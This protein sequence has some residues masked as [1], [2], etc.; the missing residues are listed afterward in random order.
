M[1]E[2]IPYTLIGVTGMF[3]LVY[4]LVRV[5]HNDNILKALKDIVKNDNALEQPKIQEYT[6]KLIYNAQV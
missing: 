6:T 4:H 3:A 5:A 1:I 2:Y